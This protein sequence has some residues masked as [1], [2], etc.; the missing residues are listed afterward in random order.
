MK[1]LL[2]VVFAI[3]KVQFFVSAYLFSNGLFLLAVFT[4]IFFFTQLIIKAIA[5]FCNIYN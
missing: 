4:I 2:R 3:F 5:R 1:E